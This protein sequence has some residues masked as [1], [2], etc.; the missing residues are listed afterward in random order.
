MIEARLEEMQAHATAGRQIRVE[1]AF[2]RFRDLR[3]SI[4]N[5]PRRW[6]YEPHGSVP[7]TA[8]PNIIIQR[9]EAPATWTPVAPRASM[10]VM[11]GGAP[12]AAP[13]ATTSTAAPVATSTGQPAF[14]PVTGERLVPVS[15]PQPLFDPMTG[16]RLVPEPAAPAPRF[17]PFTG[18]PLAEAV[19]A[20]RFDPQT[21]LP[22]DADTETPPPYQP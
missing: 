19:P 20:P 6:T 4:G 21:G 10:P 7:P 3:Q 12:A 9:Q 16:E 1:N 2:K 8:L 22:L 17:D 18:K 13:P 15:T 14:D 11:V 5:H